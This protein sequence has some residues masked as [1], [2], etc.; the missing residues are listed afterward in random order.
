M[1]ELNQPK[2]NLLTFALYA[3]DFD[4]KRAVPAKGSVVTGTLLLSLIAVFS[5]YLTC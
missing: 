2:T 3:R 4:P 1:L 5:I